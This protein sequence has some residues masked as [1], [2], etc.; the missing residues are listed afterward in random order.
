MV[1][2]KK[3]TNHRGS[4]VARG[5]GDATKVLEWRRSTNFTTRTVG[6]LSARARWPPPENQGDVRPNP[7]RE[8]KDNDRLSGRVHLSSRRRA[9]AQ[10]GIRG[11][12]RDPDRCPNGPSAPDA[13]VPSQPQ[14]DRGRRHT[15]TVWAPTSHRRGIHHRPHHLQFAIT[16]S[17]S[18]GGGGVPRRRYPMRPRAPPANPG[19][20][21]HGAT[22]SAHT[23]RPEPSPHPT[24]TRPDRYREWVCVG[25][26]EGRGPR[27]AAQDAKAT[28]DAQ[29]R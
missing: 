5:Q 17:P 28:D 26:S 20:R 25:V 11:F 13:Y 2:E 12:S 10:I 18:V 27:P 3:D 23:T 4:G 16:S 9:W 24:P 6:S 8:P 7:N 1:P 15:P 29:A 14:V 22:P 21:D 19:G